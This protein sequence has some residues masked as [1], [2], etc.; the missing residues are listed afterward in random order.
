NTTH[1]LYGLPRQETQRVAVASMIGTQEGERSVA[2]SRLANNGGCAG[3]N[4]GDLAVTEITP[5]ISGRKYTQSE[6]SAST[7]LA[8]RVHNQTANSVFAYRISYKINNNAWVTNI[9]ATS[10]IGSGSAVIGLGNIDLSMPGKYTITAVVQNL[11]TPDQ[12]RSNDTLETTLF[13][14]ANESL[15]LHDDLVID[16]EGHDFSLTGKSTIGLD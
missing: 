15:N 3:I 5:G 9:Y 2:V 6:F 1:T 7:P 16:F 12:V 10:I 13:H 4:N 8:V 11:I 14:W